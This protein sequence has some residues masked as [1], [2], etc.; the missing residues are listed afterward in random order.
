MVVAESGPRR[1]LTWLKE[2][3]QT[4]KTHV[5]LVRHQV[6]QPLLDAQQVG[7]GRHDDVDQDLRDD[8]DEGVLPGEGVEQGGDGVEDLG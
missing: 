2:K 7:G 8:G 5:A 6:Q 4:S 3:R 1:R